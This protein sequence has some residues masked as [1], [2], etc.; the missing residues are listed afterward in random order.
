[1]Q[2]TYPSGDVRVLPAFRRERDL[3]PDRAYRRFSIRGEQLPY[4]ETLAL[5]RLVELAHLRTSTATIAFMAE[6]S[7]AGRRAGD[8]PR[9]NAVAPSR[10]A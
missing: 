8:S 1:V 4:P 3:G 7:S 10:R 9:R 6:R 2:Q 5:S